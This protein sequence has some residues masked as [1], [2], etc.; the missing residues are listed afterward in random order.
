V[1]TPRP[2]LTSD[3]VIYLPGIMGSELVDANGAIVWGMK[4]SLLFRQAL[5]GT[6]L[7]RLIPKPDDG[8]VASRPIQWPSAIPLLSSV[9]PY[10]ALA[11]RLQGTVFHADAVKAFAYDWRRS[12]ADAAAALKPF[13]QAH[14]RSW[15]ERWKNVAAVER[16]GLPDPQLTLVCHSMGGLV[17][18]YFAAFLDDERLVRRIITLGTPFAGSLNAVQALATG[19]Q[20]PF[21]LFA[22]SLRDAVRTMPGVYELVARW[23]CVGDDNARR[24]IDPSDLANIGADATLA[25]NAFAVMDKLSGAFSGGGGQRPPV[26]CLVGVTQPTLQSVRFDA[27]AA[28]FE[29]AIDGVDHRGDGTVFRFSAVPRGEEPSYLPQ[30]HAA[31][32]KTEEAL[33]FVAAVLTEAEL[34]EFQAPPG[35]GLRVPAAVKARVPFSIEVLD[36]PPG[37]TCRLYDAE[38]NRL[39]KTVLA[40]PR[41]DL[42]AAQMTT[43]EPGLYRVTATGG[44]FSPVEQLVAAFE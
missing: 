10:T 38:T 6:V 13:A 43:P 27:G 23:R 14:L 32:A 15:R 25:S 31:V 16:Q 34:G 28:A 11:H 30:S 8:I 5:F 3:A 44:G 35:V 19:E 21:G 33:A 29:E 9:E 17:A 2:A 40:A 1:P 36:G 24:Q 22:A 18:S 41:D 4:P 37:I 20:L 12:I 7:S 42:Q 26:R 39:V